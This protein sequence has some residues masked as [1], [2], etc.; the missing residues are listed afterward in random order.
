MRLELLS[1]LNAERAARRTAILVTELASGRQQLVAEG[2]VSEHPLRR[3][4]EQCLRTRISATER[5]PQG[6]VFVA[7]YAPGQ[8]L[9]ITGAVHI[10]QFLAPMAAMLGYAVVIVDPRTAFATIDRFPDVTI[11]PAWPEDALPPLSIDRHTAFVAL[12]HDPKIDDFALVHALACRCFYIGALGSNRTHARR[13]ERLK[14][15]G[16]SEEAL[17]TL[18][19][20]IGLAIGAQSPAELALSIMAEI[21]SRRAQLE[22]DPEEWAPAFRKIA[23]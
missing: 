17:A 15:K 20:P 1:R 23:L 8:R 4:L 14:Q 6:E 12:T 9:V 10:S 22:R 7:V 5:T 19:A 18:H 2:E 13:V 16:V 11:V 3:Q 21:T